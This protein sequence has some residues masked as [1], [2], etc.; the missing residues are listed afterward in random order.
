MSRMRFMWIVMVVA[1]AMA[2]SWGILPA[3][4]ADQV[5]GAPDQAAQEAQQALAK[6]KAAADAAE[7]RKMRDDAWQKRKA[8]RDFIAQHNQQEQQPG[9][10]PAAPGNDGKDGAK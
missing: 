6:Q 7:A 2:L 9:A 4:A 1:V 10:A 5:P 3:R 8:M